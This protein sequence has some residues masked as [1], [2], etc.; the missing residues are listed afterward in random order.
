MNKTIAIVFLVVVLLLG[1][2]LLSD[3]DADAPADMND[4]EGT[5][6]AEVADTDTDAGESVSVTPISHATMVLNWNDTIIYADPV[7]GT[8]AFD[9]Q[10]SPDLILVTD[11]HGDHLS[12]GTLESV[13]S[14]DTIIVAPPAVAALLPENLSTRTRVLAN[15]ERTEF[16]GI[17]VE[18]IPA[19]NLPEQGIEI[20]HEQ[21]RGNGYVLET[22]GERVYIAGDTAD[23]PE[24]RSLEN[25]DMA[26]IPMNLPYTMDVRR[27]ADGV[28]AFAP[29]QVYPYH[30][31]TPE[32]FSDVERFRVLVVEENPDIEVILLDWYPE[33]EPADGI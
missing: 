24:M 17:M 27:A 20:R 3:N 26:F 32:G 22:D 11:V 21:G 23:I 7:G 33:S 19:Y 15:G 18:A 6:Q 14:S 2:V 28:L 12:V 30:F 16:H 5:E 4:T 29:A 1:Y 10:P 25:I 13:V 31:R 8:E 9:G